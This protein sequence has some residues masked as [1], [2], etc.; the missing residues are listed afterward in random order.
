MRS[1]CAG[2]VELSREAGD[3]LRTPLLDAS[4][5]PLARSFRGV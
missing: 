2:R 3:V 4:R 1:A 5:L